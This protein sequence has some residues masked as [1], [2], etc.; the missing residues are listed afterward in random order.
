KVSGRRVLELRTLLNGC[1]RFCGQH[2]PSGLEV[3][4]LTPISRGGT[5]RDG[6]I[7]L[8][9]SRCNRAK[10]NKT[11]R[12]F[13]AW[14]KERDLPVSSLRIKGERPDRPTVASGRR[15]Y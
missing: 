3:E 10:T 4:H 7:T 14:L 9:C 5:N 13:A 12:E 1:C 2:S 11:L 6:N 15:V 8:S